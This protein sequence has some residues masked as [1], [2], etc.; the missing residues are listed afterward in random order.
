MNKNKKDVGV[1]GVFF[2]GAR[3]KPE[4]SNK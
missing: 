3:C 1:A 2:V 4:Q